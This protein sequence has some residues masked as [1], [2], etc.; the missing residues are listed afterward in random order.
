MRKLGFVS[1]KCPSCG[2]D[3]TLDDSR[4][5]GFCSYCG[6]KVAQDKLIVEHRGNISVDGIAGFNAYLDRGL[7]FLEDSSFYS[8]SQYFEKAL[9]L[10]PRCSK[11]YLG[12]L[13]CMLEATSLHGIA[14]IA[15]KPLNK[16]PLFNKAKRFADAKEAEELIKMEDEVN[17]RLNETER[18]Y[19][20]SL[21]VSDNKI[22]LLNRELENGKKAD[23]KNKAKRIVWKIVLILSAVLS[24]LFLFIGLGLVSESKDGAVAALVI[25][26]LFIGCLAVSI[27][28]LTK[29][30]KRINKYK[31]I[32]SDIDKEIESR[33]IV[34]RSYN[35]WKNSL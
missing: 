16:Y 13:A 25:G 22:E 21:A 35:N 24:Q 3:I 34:E 31:G 29:A 4:E 27:V 15:Q 1:L 23:K 5:F 33:A 20:N 7:L 17:G 9:D 2:A 26:L 30:N 32:A 19:Q 12:K 11:G 18:S 6:T 14:D 8:A 10:N 28:F